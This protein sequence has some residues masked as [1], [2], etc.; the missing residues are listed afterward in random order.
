M[1]DIEFFHNKNSQAPMEYCNLAAELYEVLL[2][3]DAFEN[4]V[5]V[6]NHYSS[7]LF[8]FPN[9]KI[10]I[11][12]TVLLDMTSVPCYITFK[13]GAPFNPTCLTIGQLSSWL[14]KNWNDLI[15]GVKK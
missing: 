8:L 9:G 12:W 13:N 5:Q 7:F 10:T 2:G 11:D 6:K 15:T 3:Q 14:Q 4:G 1:N